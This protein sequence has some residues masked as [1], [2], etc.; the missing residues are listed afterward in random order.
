[1]TNKKCALT[2]AILV[3]LT[4][5]HGT[6]FAADDTTQTNNKKQK[7]AVTQLQ[8]V[9]VTATH[10]VKPLQEVP[11]SISAISA[12]QLQ[13]SNFSQLSDLQYLAPGLS[14]SQSATAANGGGFQVRGI[15]TQTYSLGTDQTVGT[16]VDDVVLSLPRDPGVSGFNDIQDVE[17]LRGPQG[18]LFGKNASAGV[19]AIKTNDPEIGENSADVHVA[20]GSR[21]ERVVQAV[22]NVAV[23]NDVALRVAVYDQSQDGAIPNVF[24]D[25]HVEDNHGNGVRAKLLWQPSDKFSL[26]VTGEHQ[27][28]FIRDPYFLYSLGTD[29]NYNVLF[30]GFP[31]VGGNHFVSYAN[32]DWYAEQSVTGSS[33]KATYQINDETSF[34]SITAFRALKVTQDE[35]LDQSPAD[36]LDNSDSTLRGHQFTQ[37][38]RFVGKAFSD[39]LDY[40]AGAFFDKTGLESNYIVYGKV[41]PPYTLPFYIDATGGEQRSTLWTKNFAFYGNTTYSL[42]DKLAVIMGARYTHDNVES[43][44]NPYIPTEIDG[45]PAIPFGMQLP[46]W[47]SAAK[48]DVSGKVGLQYNVSHD[49][50]T[51]AT[52]ST[53][54]KGPA[55]N[56]AATSTQKINPE[57][58]V[59]YEL[60][61]KSDFLDHRL[62][63]NGDVYWDTFHNFQAQAFDTQTY[64]FV[65]TNAGAMRT[66]GAEGELSWRATQHLTLG[67]NAAFTDAKYL[68]YITACPVPGDVPC[69]TTDGSSLANF[70]GQDPAFVSRYT[71]TLHASYMHPIND[72][73]VFDADGG[74]AWRS[75]FYNVIGQPQTKTGS[76]GIFNGTIGISSDSDSWRIGLYTR[77]LFNK[78]FRDYVIYTSIINT[79]GYFQHM[80]PDA[81]RTI[82]ISLDL[83]I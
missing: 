54:Y 71:G 36:I 67:M 49:V 14:Y 40:A 41:L 81:F 10:A 16:V 80:T 45:L 4:M 11:I 70:R 24:H 44:N 38:F 73:L 68:S 69:Y 31:N 48:G 27:N 50:M 63:L 82:G 8:T 57:K 7:P 25:W 6:S 60:G 18:T 23:S 2:A 1:M 56:V 72:G 20:V 9:T 15:G 78:H 74:W 5:V 53:G 37:E 79:D 75:S 17:V 47:N 28:L 12:D 51:Y 43:G 62:T 42:T 65:L 21:D 64:E 34:T 46:S 61:V 13:S 83:K 59:N 35:D 32:E 52:V 66:R 19:V 58:S 55:I 39:K 3:A 30:A 22:G 33:V 26:V 77:N 76:Y 29:P